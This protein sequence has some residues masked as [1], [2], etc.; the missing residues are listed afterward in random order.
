MRAPLVA[1]SVVAVLGLA[2]SISLLAR[3]D[4][5]ATQAGG[6]AHEA[7]PSAPARQATQPAASITIPAT[8][9][10]L[11]KRFRTVLAGQAT[12]TVTDTGAPVSVHF[13]T[14]HE[15]N[16]Q[17]KTGTLTRSDA[18]GRPNGAAIV[19]ALTADGVTGGFDLQILQNTSDQK[20]TCDDPEHCTVRRLP[21]GSTLAIGHSSINGGGVTYQVDLIS[22]DGVE[23]LM[24]VSN[25][26]SPKG[27]SPVL[28]AHPPLTT[29]QM[30]AIVTSDRW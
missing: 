6:S 19:G 29:D 16:T 7:T 13:P 18:A 27:E 15:P 21:D 23:I 4:E 17:G 8:A 24:H 5:P 26:R 9:D 14:H 11:A 25:Q 3:H 12:F 2:T 30:A 22:A 20:A 28:A 1:A 10:D